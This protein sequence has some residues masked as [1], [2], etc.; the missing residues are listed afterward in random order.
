MPTIFKSAKMAWITG[1]TSALLITTGVSLYFWYFDEDADSEDATYQSL[2]TISN[3]SPKPNLAG[4]PDIYAHPVFECRKFYNEVCYK[5]GRKDPTGKSA[6]SSQS[7]AKVL[8]LFADLVRANPKMSPEKIDEKLVQAVYTPDRTEKMHSLFD[9]SKKILKRMFSKLAGKD[10]SAVAFYEKRLD[11]LKLELPPPATLYSDEREILT[12]DDAL[13][14]EENEVPTKIRIGGALAYQISSQFNLA[15]TLAHELAHA[16]SPCPWL[17]TGKNWDFYER[18]LRCLGYTKDRVLIECSHPGKMA[19]ILADWFATQVV[20][21]IIRQDGKKFA[22]D[23][24]IAAIKNTVRDLCAEEGDMTR[25]RKHDWNHSHP[26]DSDRINGI[27][28]QHPR[29]QNA[30]HCNPKPKRL[31]F[32]IPS[33]C[34]KFMELD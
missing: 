16:L 19:E 26:R 27:F 6:L 34:F 3:P 32:R 21:E 5:P 10:R 33:A 2:Q 18:P 14:Y 9:R 1:V 17:A 13:Y 22:Y 23:E 4:P 12:G 8:R 28:A 15:Q 31:P 20:V 24:K 30:L 11:Q 7:E 29:I 25:D